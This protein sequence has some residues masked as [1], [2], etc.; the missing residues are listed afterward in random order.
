LN[1]QVRT[2]DGHLCFVEKVT[3]KACRLVEGD[4][5]ED[6]ESLA[7]KWHVE[8]VTEDDKDFVVVREASQERDRQG[9]VDFDCNYSSGSP[10]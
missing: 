5:S 9:R 4:V 1:D 2:P 3:E 10:R 6:P 7:R 8:E